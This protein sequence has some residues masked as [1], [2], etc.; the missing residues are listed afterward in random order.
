M[1][2]K[3]PIIALLEADTSDQNGGVTEADACATFS[4]AEYADALEKFIGKQCKE[5]AEAWGQPVTMPTG[6]EIIAAFFG[7]PA[8]VW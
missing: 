3:K 8:I 6:E 2:R 7:C 5:W 4:S 1:V